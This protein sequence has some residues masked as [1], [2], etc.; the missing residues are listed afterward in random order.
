MP[1]VWVGAS[2]PDS[3]FAAL[4]PTSMRQEL[5]ARINTSRRGDPGIARADHTCLAN[6]AST[7]SLVV[8]L[9]RLV[10]PHPLFTPRRA[11]PSS[12]QWSLTCSLLFAAPASASP[13]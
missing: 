1:R 5:R 2:V 11:M 12:E 9:P 4:G 13:G 10:T 7:G 8:G 3:S 6:M